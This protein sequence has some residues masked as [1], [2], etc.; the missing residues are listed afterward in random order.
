MAGTL[1]L[2][3]KFLEDHEISTTTL[4]LRNTDD[5]TA[6]TDFFN[7][8]RE[9]DD[10]LGFRGYRLQFEERN[11]L[12]NQIRGRH[13]LGA[14]TRERLRFLDNFLAFVPQ[15]TSIDW[16]YSDSTAETE[17]PNQVE[18]ASQTVT[19]PMTAVVLG[20]QVT[21]SNTSGDFRF[22]DLDDDVENYGWSFALPIDTQ[23]S[24]ISNDQRK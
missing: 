2:G 8:N 9:I 22:T 13:Y 18:I 7:E 6:T 15:E 14:D 19:D 4:W 1:S 3:A 20:E 23:R 10:G 11:L 16:F 24:Y 12:T 5:E 17:I 21:L